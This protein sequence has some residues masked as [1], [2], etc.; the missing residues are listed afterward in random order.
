MPPPPDESPPAELRASCILS[1]KL[2][3][4]S[5]FSVHLPAKFGLSVAAAA[6]AG[7]LSAAGFGAS[8]ACCGSCAAYDARKTPARIAR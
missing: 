5:A 2:S 8:A 1:R 4:F 7:L 3:V 6:A